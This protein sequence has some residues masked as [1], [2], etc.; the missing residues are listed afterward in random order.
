MGNRP[1]N[2]AVMD[3]ISSPREMLTAG[4]GGV[5]V[6]TSHRIHDWLFRPEAHFQDLP[7]ARGLAPP[8]DLSNRLSGHFAASI[9]GKRVWPAAAMTDQSAAMRLE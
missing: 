4:E 1:R 8:S 7:Q 3:S 5:E 2:W 9:V 6:S